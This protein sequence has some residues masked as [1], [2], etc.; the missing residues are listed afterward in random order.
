MCVL[1][2]GVAPNVVP[3]KFIISKK[4]C[5]KHRKRWFCLLFVSSALDLRFSPYDDHEELLKMVRGW[6][7]EA[8]EDCTLKFIQRSPKYPMTS[9]EDSDPWWK[10]FSAACAKQ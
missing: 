9:T 2:G 5:S 3:D 4:P 10:A 6:L 1:Q 8:G 7:D